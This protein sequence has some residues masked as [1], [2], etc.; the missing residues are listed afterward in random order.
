MVDQSL[1]GPYFLGQNGGL[2]GRQAGRQAYGRDMR[3]GQKQRCLIG[4]K[5][6]KVDT[7]H[8]VFLRFRLFATSLFFFHNLFSE[9][10]C[11]R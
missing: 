7:G 9:C 8:Y 6:A 10:L 5:G 3:D 4:L 2:A 1:S 11:L